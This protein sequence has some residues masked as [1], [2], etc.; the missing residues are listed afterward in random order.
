MPQSSDDYVQ[1]RRPHGPHGPRRHRVYVRHHGRGRRAHSNRDA[2]QSAAETRRDRRLLR[3]SQ[4]S[5]PA[6]ERPP[7][8]MALQI[9]RPPM[10]KTPPKRPPSRAKPIRPA[11]DPAVA[12]AAACNQNFPLAV[13]QDVWPN[14]RIWL[15]PRANHER[16]RTNAA[17]LPAARSSQSRLQ[18]FQEAPQAHAARL[19]FTHRRRPD[20]ERQHSAIVAI[21]PPNDYPARPSGTPWSNKAASNEPAKANTNSCGPDQRRHS[22]DKSAKVR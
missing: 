2:D 19:R 11:N 7:A 1:P 20:V 21:T 6:P 14:T 5:R 15:S 18:S 4:P 8:P 13:S 22:C 12:T 17:R 10:A 3:W 16:F 9:H